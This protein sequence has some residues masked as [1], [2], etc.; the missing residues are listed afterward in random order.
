MISNSQFIKNKPIIDG[1]FTQRTNS[2][3]KV[4][5]STFEENY[6]FSRGSVIFGDY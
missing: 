2:I 1:F 6:S 4:Y 5:N 3:L